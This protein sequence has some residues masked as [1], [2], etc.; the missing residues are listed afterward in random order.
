MIAENFKVFDETINIDRNQ[1]KSTGNMQTKLHFKK[2]SD[3]CRTAI[4]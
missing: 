1:R 3:G 4:K 2:L